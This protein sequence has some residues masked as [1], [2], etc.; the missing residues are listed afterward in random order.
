[1]VGKLAAS[2]LSED[3]I[4]TVLGVDPKTLRKEF[5]AEL[6]S[7]AI[8]ANE[9]VEQS[10]LRLATE[11]NVTA[12][13][14]WLKARAGWR[15]KQDVD[16]DVAATQVPLPMRHWPRSPQAAAAELL[17]RRRIRRS[18]EAW[19][20]HAL[21]PQGLVPAAHH[22][23]LIRELEQLYRT[24]G[25]RLMVL[26]PPGSAKS[27][28]ASKLFAPWLFAQA[29]GLSIIGASNAAR[30]AKLFSGEVQSYV[31]EHANTL[32]CG[33]LTRSVE[34]WRTANGGQYLA[35]GV[36]STITGFRA[37]LAVID[38]PVKSRE[39]ADSE[40]AREKVW[41]WW[42]SDLRTR[43]RPGG[44]VALVMTRWHEDD[45]GGRLLM[46][47]AGAW[48]VVKLPALAGSADPWAG[49]LASRYG[50]TMATDTQPNWRR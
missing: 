7:G 38:D 1:M 32:R 31:R 21:E 9:Q 34:R 41:Q 50:L 16:V 3:A 47:S 48:R 29:S 24:P 14:F 46:H 18:F 11:G 37:D 33:V 39:E 40:T 43:L 12:A 13:I 35:A 22:L 42:L 49:R 45:L 19:C 36:G 15:E 6:D 26:M 2:G 8:K 28:Y 27:T 4:A 30:L 44:R 5:R 10:L 25:G 23:L 17:K 20:R